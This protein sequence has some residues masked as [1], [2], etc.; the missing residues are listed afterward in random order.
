MLMKQAK[1]KQW[2]ATDM[3]QAA[4]INMQQLRS[5]WGEQVAHLQGSQ[6]VKLLDPQGVDLG[7]CRLLG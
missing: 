4:Q 2:L 6:N 7:C 5:R 1:T 3:L